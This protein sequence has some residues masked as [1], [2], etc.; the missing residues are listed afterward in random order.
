MDSVK[1]IERSRLMISKDCST[2]K[3]SRNILVQE[4]DST[5]LNSIDVD[6]L[7]NIDDESTFGQNIQLNQLPEL[8]LTE[9]EK[10][11]LQK[12]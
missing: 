12:I 10:L 11:K 4:N 9:S 5:I 1:Q 2:L 3:N 6:D 7:D 8:N